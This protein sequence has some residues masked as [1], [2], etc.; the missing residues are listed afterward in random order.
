M[1]TTNYQKTEQYR[2]NE[3]NNLEI[4]VQQ[5]KSI[6]LQERALEL[7]GKYTHQ[8]LDMETNTTLYFYTKRVLT[9]NTPIFISKTLQKRHTRRTTEYRNYTQQK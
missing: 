7:E 9:R 4:K 6:Q 8:K 3:I 2:Y 1:T 5:S